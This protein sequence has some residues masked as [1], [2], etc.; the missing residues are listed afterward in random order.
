MILKR[1]E[2]IEIVTDRLILN[3]GIIDDYVRVY[4]YDMRKLRDINGE[5]CFK[6]HDPN[7]VRD[8]FPEGLDTYYEN[9]KTKNG[10]FDWII[11]LKSGMIPIGNIISDRE[12]PELKSCE[13][14][15]NLHP[16]YWGNG[17]IPE[18]IEAVLNHL[19][20]LG[21]E[22]V[23]YSYEQDN[24]KSKRVSEKLGFQPFKYKKE[25][26]IK[27]NKYIEITELIMSNERWFKLKEN[28]KTF[29]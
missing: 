11:Y 5:F 14:S 26:R 8:W 7:D 4:E 23:L 28:K 22:N 24:K 10:L 20:G 25:Y 9:C 21:Y 15:F 16:N 17:F 3:K 27:E 1:Y 12:K 6:R 2:T 19:F 29:K 18:S 13:L